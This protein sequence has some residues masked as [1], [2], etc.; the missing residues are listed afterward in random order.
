VNTNSSTLVICLPK[1]SQKFMLCAGKAF[2][3]CTLRRISILPYTEQ[4][5]LSVSG[6]RRAGGWRLGRVEGRG[7]DGADVG[8][9]LRLV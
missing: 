7:K 1:L 3:C 4:A 8:G 5:R 9:G 2:T 6:R